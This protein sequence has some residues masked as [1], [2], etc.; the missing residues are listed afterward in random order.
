[1]LREIGMM[2]FR[3]VGIRYVG[4]GLL[5]L[6]LMML[7]GC[8]SVYVDGSMR[9]IPAS[10]FRQVNPKHPVQVLFEFQTNGVANVFATK[11]FKQTVIEQVEASNLFAGVS[12]EPSEGGALLGIT[13]NNVSA[14]DEA[15]SKGFATGLT[16]GLVGNQIT[17]GYVCTATYRHGIGVEPVVARARHAIHTTIGASSSPPNATKA[18]SIKEAVD[19][20]LKQ[21]I[22]NVLNDLSHEADFK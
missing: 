18:S 14:Q 11:E 16:F 9:E 10:Q 21:V 19:I 8:S 17:D 3:C 5:L 15:F 7:I 20:M 2:M 1:M 4:R 22:S 12:E 6:L 13:V